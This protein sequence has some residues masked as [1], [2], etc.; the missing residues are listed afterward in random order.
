LRRSRIGRTGTSNWSRKF[1]PPAKSPPIA[2]LD[3][4][5]Y[6]WV[7]DLL[8]GIAGGIDH[9]VVFHHLQETV[10][11][12]ARAGHVVLIGHGSTFMTRDLAGGL[13]LR[14]IAP[15][16]L[17]LKSV[18]A[19]FGL[20]SRQAARYISRVEKRRRAFFARFWPGRPLGPDLFAAVLNVAELNEQKLIQAIMAM[21][22]ASTD[23]G[24]R[25]DRWGKGAIP[26]PI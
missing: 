2:S 25:A 6:S 12:L 26:R 17:R 9:M 3:T 1:P 20:S 19:R 24:A 5:G 15:M 21:L 18:G 4:S 16:N 8:C 13:R 22:P 7:D 14:L 23:L 10:R 11:G